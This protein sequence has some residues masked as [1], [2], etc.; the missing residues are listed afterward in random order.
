MH[1]QFSSVAVSC[2]KEE[3][4]NQ[5]DQKDACDLL[6]QA[7]FT[8]SEIEG[9]RRLRQDYTEN[10]GVQALAERRRLEFARWLV[11]TGRLTEQIA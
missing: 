2:E 8:P 5:M 6:R 7:G 11:T 1:E 10:E 4:M 9:L 3:S